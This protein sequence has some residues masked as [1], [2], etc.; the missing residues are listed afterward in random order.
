[1]EDIN[2]MKYFSDTEWA[3]LMEIKT[4]LYNEL[5]KDRVESAFSNDSF[6][7]ILIWD[8]QNN[9][10][11]CYEDYRWIV[12]TTTKHFINTYLVEV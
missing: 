6:F 4:S 12:K 10:C 11:I 7:D 2:T 5:G 1:M 3:T 8:I 9:P